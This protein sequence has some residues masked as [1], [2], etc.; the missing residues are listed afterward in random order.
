MIFLGTVQC[1]ASCSHRLLLSL[2]LSLSLQLSKV[3]SRNQRRLFAERLDELGPS[4]RYCGY[5]IN[6]AGGS[7]PDAGDL[8]GLVGGSGAGSELL[9]AK[10]SAMLAEAR[11]AQAES[12]SNVEWR[13]HAL[14]VRSE[15]V[16]E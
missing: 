15:K 16:K 12:M 9:Q 3:G 10:L 8:A 11:R 13:G 7:V 1:H 4:L 14:P 6:R 2:S 5:Q